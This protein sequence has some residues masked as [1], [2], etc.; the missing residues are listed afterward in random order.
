MIKN[1]YIICHITDHRDVK[2]RFKYL[3]ILVIIIFFE[4]V[5]SF[6]AD[7]QMIGLGGNNIINPGADVKNNSRSS[8]YIIYQGLPSEILL[9]YVIIFI[10]NL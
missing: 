8:H 2:L 3:I 9:S 6:G 5:P 1:I 10:M 4:T 7:C